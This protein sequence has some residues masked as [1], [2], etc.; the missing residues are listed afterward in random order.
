[1]LA[2]APSSPPACPWAGFQLANLTFCEADRCAWVTQPANTWSNVGFLL[3]GLLVLRAARRTGARVAGLL[4]LIAIV[5]AFTSSLLHGT[6]TFMGQAADQIGMFLESAFFVALSAGRWLDLGRAR[7]VALHLVLFAGS[8]A[9]LLRFQTLGIALFT[10]HMVT[11]A[12]IEV[13]LLVRDGK[14]TDYRPLAWVAGLFAV[15]YA[16]WWLDELRIVC[17][18]GNHVFTLHSAWHFLG[19]ASFYAWFRF[20]AQFER[21]LGAPAPA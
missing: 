20:Y 19:A 9:L 1:M 15:S 18:P 2:P 3:V 10:A 12:A 7:V 14:G 8:T 21:G 6:G 17:D 4:G 11:F 16:L 13:R 5:N